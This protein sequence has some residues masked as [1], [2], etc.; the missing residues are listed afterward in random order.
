MKRSERREIEG[1][2]GRKRAGGGKMGKM[3]EENVTGV[4][5]GW[6]SG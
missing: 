6:R 2:E 1:G 5:D 4:K 3:G